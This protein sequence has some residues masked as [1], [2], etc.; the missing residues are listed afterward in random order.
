MR[1]VE[2]RLA[3]VRLGARRLRAR[4]GRVD[5]AHVRPARLVLDLSA[6]RDA[7]DLAPGALRN[8][9][10]GAVDWLG[11]V[12]VGFL[13][14][15]RADHPALLDLVRFAHRLECPTRL[16]TTGP[17]LDAPRALALVDRGLE[18]A[19]VT[20]AGVSDARQQAVLGVDAAS[21]TTALQ[22]L[23]AAREARGAAL[24]I[25]V[26]VPFVAGVEAEL[27]ALVAWATQLGA[28]GLRLVAPHAPADAPRTVA[29]FDALPT[30]GSCRTSRSARA[31][32]RALSGSD[33][34]GPGLPR[35]RAALPCPVGG[36]RLAV[37]AR[38]AA[39]CCPHKPG[40]GT[41]G[42]DVPALWRQ[43][44]PHLAAIRACDR[45]C[46]HIELAPEETVRAALATGA[47]IE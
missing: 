8:L 41:F 29:A 16:T 34:P 30:D 13:V 21:A 17:G 43:A 31:A 4:L 5:P 42:G 40:I 19:R 45:A 46:A 22:A 12:P 10:V 32:L 18:A 28:D 39:A 47:R 37:D 2:H 36:Q 24:D 3:R 35:G 25:E 6:P 15:A 7:A 23:V 11:P 14:G 38:G 1:M 27:E 9:V 44:G 26:A 33:D 20:V